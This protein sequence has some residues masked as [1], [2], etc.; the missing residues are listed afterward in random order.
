MDLDE[1]FDGVSHPGQCILARRLGA[2]GVVPAGDFGECRCGGCE[3][4]DQG[5]IINRATRMLTHSP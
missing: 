3:S 5:G 1:A 2:S 4:G